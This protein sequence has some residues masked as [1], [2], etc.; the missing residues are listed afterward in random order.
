MSCICSP[1]CA[2]LQ[3]VCIIGGILWICH[4]HWGEVRS[5]CVIRTCTYLLWKKSIPEIPGS[6]EFPVLVDKCLYMKLKDPSHILVSLFSLSL[7]LSPE[8]SCLE[9]SPS[10][11]LVYIHWYLCHLGGHWRSEQ[12]GHCFQANSKGIQMSHCVRTLQYLMTVYTL[13]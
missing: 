8:Q 5:A 13:Y 7:S 6:L 12:H 9:P 1:C 4:Q 2:G 3:T 10:T 11:W